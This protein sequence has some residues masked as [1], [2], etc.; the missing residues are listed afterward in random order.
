MSKLIN[1]K[2]IQIDGVDTKDYPD[3]CD[4]YVSY[5]EYE[6]GTKLTDEE[7]EGL[8]EYAQENAFESLL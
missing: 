8:S 7:C 4:A 1:Y 3:F 6:D 5:A 2:S